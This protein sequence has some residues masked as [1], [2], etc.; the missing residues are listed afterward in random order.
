MG[1]DY[2]LASNAIVKAINQQ[3]QIESKRNQFT[4][5]LL[6]Q[7]IKEKRRKQLAQEKEEYMSPMERHLA[8][9]YMEENPQEINELESV[10]GGLGKVAQ[11]QKQRLQQQGQRGTQKTSYGTKAPSTY[12]PPKQKDQTV[13]MTATGFKPLTPK[14]QLMRGVQRKYESGMQLTPGEK[15]MLGMPTG[16]SKEEKIVGELSVGAYLDKGYEVPLE[17]KEEAIRYATMKLGNK[18]DKKYPEAREALEKKYGPD[19]K[20]FPVNQFKT[21]PNP[22]RAAYE[23]LVNEVGMEPDNA[24][25]WLEEN[26]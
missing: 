22:L 2:G 9:R 20:D 16:T 17:T 5:T 1:Y 8:R 18:W 13:G 23:Y 6:M 7:A 3:A 10:G 26:N 14:E 15:K 11:R 4:Q 19:I 12:T 25:Q 21:Q 24:K